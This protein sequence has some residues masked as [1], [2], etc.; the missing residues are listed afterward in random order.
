LTPAE[1]PTFAAL[2][3]AREFP[4]ASY[5][6]TGE[7]FAAARKLFVRDVLGPAGLGVLNVTGLAQVEAD[8][9]VLPNALRKDCG[10]GDW[11][12]SDLPGDGQLQE[13]DER[14]DQWL[15]SLIDRPGIRRLLVYY[16]GHGGTT[17]EGYYLAVKASR[18]K[19]YSRQSIRFCQLAHSIKR[20]NELIKLTSSYQCF[21]MIDACYAAKGVAHLLQGQD[22]ER[23][24]EAIQAE[25][26]SELHGQG[27][28]LLCSSPADKPSH[29]LPD[30]SNTS[31]MAALSAAVRKGMEAYEPLLSVR[32][33]AGLMWEE[34]KQIQQAVEDHN[35]Q[36]TDQ[37]LKQ[38]FEAI[39]PQV[40]CPKQ[41][42]GKDLAT[43]GLITN[44]WPYAIDV[45]IAW[46]REHTRLTNLAT[47]WDEAPKLSDRL[48]RGTELYAAKSWANSRDAHLP[49]IPDVVRRFLTASEDRDWE[50]TYQKE[51]SHAQSRLS[52][53]EYLFALKS[54]LALRK[55][56][57][58]APDGWRAWERIGYR[59]VSLLQQTPLEQSSEQLGEAT[60][61]TVSIEDWLL[62]IGFRDGSV[63]IQQLRLPIL[64][65]GK[66]LSGE[67]YLSYHSTG[68][69]MGLSGER[70]R[71]PAS[72]TVCQDGV[73]VSFSSGGVRSMPLMV[74]RS[75]GAEVGDFSVSHVGLKIYGGWRSDEDPVS[76]LAGFQAT[77]GAVQKATLSC[78][79]RLRLWKRG[80]EW[81]LA[82]EIA[83]LPRDPDDRYFGLF[84]LVEGSETSRANIAAVSLAG[85]VYAVDGEGNPNQYFRGHDDAP[86]VDLPLKSRISSIEQ[87]KMEYHES[88]LLIQTPS[89]VVVLNQYGFDVFPTNEDHE[90]T[91]ALLLNSKTVIIGYREGVIE[92]H[93]KS[94]II[95]KNWHGRQFVPCNVAIVELER[96]RYW[97]HTDQWV[98][99]GF[100]S[101]TQDGAVLI[102]RNIDAGPCRAIHP[103]GNNIRSVC[104]ADEGKK[105]VSV[106][107]NGELALW[108]LANSERTR[109]VWDVLELR[110]PCLAT[111]ARTY[112][113]RGDV[114]CVSEDHHT[115]RG[116][117]S[118]TDQIWLVSSEGC[119]PAHWDGTAAGDRIAGRAC[120]APQQT[121]VMVF[122][123]VA[124]E[125]RVVPSPVFIPLAPGQ[126]RALPLDLPTLPI[127]SFTA[128]R[129]HLE[130]AIFY[131][132][133]TYF[134]ING[135]GAIIGP[136]NLGSR[137]DGEKGYLAASWCEYSADGRYLA[138]LVEA[139]P[140]LILMS[141]SDGKNYEV[142]AANSD[143]SLDFV[144][145]PI[146]FSPEGSHC[147]AGRADGSVIEI[148]L[149][150]Q[151]P[152]ISSTYEVAGG[153]HGRQYEPASSL[154]VSP[155]GGR[156]AAATQKGLMVWRT[157]N[158]KR[159][160][161]SRPNLIEQARFISEERLVV[162]DRMGICGVIDAS[163]GEDICTITE[164]ASSKDP[165]V[166]LKERLSIVLRSKERSEAGWCFSCVGVMP[167]ACDI[168]D[169]L[170]SLN[171]SNPD[172]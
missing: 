99:D 63:S 53:G 65:D 78:D 141:I 98:T 133:G 51:I 67:L 94:D 3:G 169:Y 137:E 130:F 35:K 15:H 148:D 143:R 126:V 79:G 127:T 41:G 20:L 48:L 37:A 55:R 83:L 70:Q 49:E 30:K 111:E 116:L 156:V 29:L 14:I 33:L 159:R 46:V 146:A 8:Q 21:L 44:R 164:Q 18:V 88:H 59:L 136:G 25:V 69:K 129:D 151:T 144:V 6:R 43:E 56:G 1:V 165:I 121:A 42:H 119:H 91:A 140:R 89:E 74:R 52:A 28:C 123:Q 87:F 109:S 101:V 155:E 68:L 16:T 54:I 132:N 157:D 163:T 105:L 47:R 85:R 100:A 168:F 34:L 27:V 118:G 149:S 135:Q 112:L 134:R 138:V 90:I 170:S 80:R 147:Y 160:L 162:I 12:N 97:S 142:D 150:G 153:G 72:G 40:H 62:A 145:G 2:F 82:K 26:E 106:S 152:I 107:R 75:P 122:P 95:T 154:D 86:F 171:A 104:F 102:W 77:F 71:I 115:S 114:L 36:Q 73:K 32:D 66:E 76:S 23:I 93:S 39:P 10:F 5:P 38:E 120:W 167:T 19:N 13:F 64:F 7:A 24:K 50:E 172:T 45:N 81:E 57:L 103:L 128:R 113:P 31:F 108:D 166:F 92:I 158:G 161:L 96:C 11:F 60:S 131:G 139:R 110:I 124:E 84:T 125:G 4:L 58:A 22:G 9:P 17:A 61:L 117:W